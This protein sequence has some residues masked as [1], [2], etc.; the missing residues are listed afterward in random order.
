[1]CVM[2]IQ[3]RLYK[4]HCV[5][6]PVP[7]A[8]LYPMMLGAIILPISL[9]ILAFTSYPGIIWVGPCAAGV[10]FGFSMVIIYISAN[11]VS[12]PNRFLLIE[13]RAVHRRLVCQLR[14]LGYCGQDAHAEPDRRE[15]A[16]MDH[17]DVP[18]YG[19]PVRWAPARAHIVRH[20]AH[21][22]HFL[23]QGWEGQGAVDA[24]RQGVSG[25]WRG[26]LNA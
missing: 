12:T 2:P 22:V 6:G 25:T 16:P 24:G 23:L 7:E 15:R 13:L 10:L 9:F 3:E 1:M 18:P 14:G 20:C 11:S 19:L 17:A 21:P 5:N 4:R 8:R 26:G